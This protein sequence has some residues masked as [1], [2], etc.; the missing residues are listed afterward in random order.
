VVWQ[1]KL[2]DFEQLLEEALYRGARNKKEYCDQL[3]LEGRL[4]FL[5]LRSR[6]TNKE[7]IS[8][9]RNA[10]QFLSKMTAAF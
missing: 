3:T 8:N 7:T 10:L 4:L 5:A 6:V 2:P 9:S 1:Q